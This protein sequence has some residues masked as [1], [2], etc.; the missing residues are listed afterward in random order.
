MEE[1]ARDIDERWTSV[2]ESLDLLFAKVGF[3]DNRQ[4]KLEAQFDV[5]T[6]VLE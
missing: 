3:V 4:Q 2:M 5:S 6:R 1:R